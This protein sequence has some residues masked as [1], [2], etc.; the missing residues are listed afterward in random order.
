MFD[1]ETDVIAAIDTI[2][3]VVLDNRTMP[4]G[5]GVTAQEAAEL[6]I[7]LTCLEELGGT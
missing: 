5:G 2:R 3:R 7:Y 4:P 1:S 6:A